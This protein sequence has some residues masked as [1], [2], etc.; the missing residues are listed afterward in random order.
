MDVI[1]AGK[2]LCLK[3]KTNWSL[4]LDKDKLKYKIGDMVRVK[5]LAW[6]EKNKDFSG[7][8]RKKSAQDSFVLEM[9]KYCGLTGTILSRNT[10]GYPIKGLNYNWCDFMFE[11][12][13]QLEFDFSNS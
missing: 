8:V 10:G 12:N 5:S 2:H 4:T 11:E 1:I 6:Y 13:E 7:S 3:K 9:K